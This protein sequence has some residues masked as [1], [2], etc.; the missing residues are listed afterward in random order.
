MNAVAVAAVSIVGGF[1]IGVGVGATV[2]VVERITAE[3]T[4]R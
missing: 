3:V 1:S 2:R 4:Q